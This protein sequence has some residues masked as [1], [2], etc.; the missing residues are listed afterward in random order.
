MEL[1]G[2]GHSAGC[3]CRL[4]VKLRRQLCNAGQWRLAAKTKE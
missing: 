3:Q 2:Q 1:R 4:C